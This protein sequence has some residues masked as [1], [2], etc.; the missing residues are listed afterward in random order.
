MCFL[1]FL[2][3]LVRLATRDNGKAVEKM[4]RN[5]HQEYGIHMVALYFYTNDDSEVRP[6]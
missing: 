3:T 4:I 6:A 1:C 5:L 2:Q